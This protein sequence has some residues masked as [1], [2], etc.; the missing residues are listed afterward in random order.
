MTHELRPALL[1]PTYS[2]V[3]RLA[4]VGL[5]FGLLGAGLMVALAPAPVAP[6]PPPAVVIREALPVPL[7]VP[8]VVAVEAPPAPVR[9]LGEVALVF[10]AGGASYLTLAALGDDGEPMPR[11]ATPRLVEDDYTY[12]AIASVAAAE[13]PR[14]YRGWAGKQVTVDA[15]CTTTVTGFAV[16]GRLTGDP[17]YAGLE[18][19]RWTATSVLTHG[20]PV[21]AARLEGCT[22]TLAR[23]ASLPPIVE[24]QRLDEPRLAAAAR[25]AAGASTAAREAQAEW[26]L[27]GRQG[28]WQDDPSTEV[29]TQVLRHP[30]TGQTFVS[31]QLHH[32]GSC[33]EPE[34]NV[35]TLHRADPDGSLVDLAASRG[36]LATIDRLVDLEGDGQLEVIGQA[37]P[38]LGRILGRSTGEVVQRLDVQFYGCSC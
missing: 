4:V 23:D 30:V 14:A 20:T 11:H 37:W 27:A 3:T 18:A 8:M 29:T 24:L 21:L 25:Q 16:V 12:A 5:G 35:W 38:G 34:L 17:G 28:R 32:A 15:A 1:T 33:G 36:E 26:A 22:G 31:V 19:E 13:V 10:T 7:A 6:L 9:A 2:H